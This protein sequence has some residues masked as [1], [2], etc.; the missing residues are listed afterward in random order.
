MIRKSCRRSK[1]R[2]N[3]KGRRRSKRRISIKGRR[4]SKSGQHLPSGCKLSTDSKYQKRPSPPYPANMCKGVILEGNDK[5][6]Y[7]SKEN[8][9]GIYTWKRFKGINETKTPEEYYSQLPHYEK[10]IY[11]TKKVRST[12]KKVEIE[13]KKNHIYLAIASWKVGDFID[14]AHNDVVEKLL[15]IAY[16]SN[17]EKD[18]RIK[19]TSYI[20]TTENIF[21]WASIEGKLY[22]YVYINNNDDKKIIIDT[23]KKYFSKKFVWD[24]KHSSAIII[25]L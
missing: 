17:R 20:W 23:F 1:R 2:I 11:D 15:K 18:N 10:P 22:L 12:L 19:N 8:K 5:K 4:R 3:I 9:N 7:I 6:R 21:Y 25:K 16:I 14:F 24:G 13:L